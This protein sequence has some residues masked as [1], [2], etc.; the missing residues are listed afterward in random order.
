MSD[1]ATG[2]NCT[3]QILRSQN[4]QKRRRGERREERRER[5][6]NKTDRKENLPRDPHIFLFPEALRG[7]LFQK[8]N[9]VLFN[10]LFLYLPYVKILLLLSK[11][12]SDMRAENEKILS[13]HRLNLDKINLTIDSNSSHHLVSHFHIVARHFRFVSL[14]IVDDSVVL[15]QFV[16]PC[17]MIS[18][19]LA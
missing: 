19:A 4:I 11:D 1:D 10:T 12:F 2:N 16:I 15:V 9:K 5:K 13:R 3:R 14:A 6:I 7:N 8:V 18:F 17:E